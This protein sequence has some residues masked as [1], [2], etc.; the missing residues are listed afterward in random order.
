MAW[1]DT[2]K[3][4]DKDSVERELPTNKQIVDRQGDVT[5]T[6][7]TDPTASGSQIALSKGLLANTAPIPYASY[8]DGQTAALTNTTAAD[9]IAAPTGGARLVVTGVSITNAHASV[10][11]GVEIRD[12]TDII[13]VIPAAANFGGAVIAMGYP[14]TADTALTA[15]CTVTGSSVTVSATAYTAT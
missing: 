12:G 10:G 9:V 1:P 2:F 7:V 13:M 14:L 3:A 4:D 6:A 11:T 8:T 15:R 5:D